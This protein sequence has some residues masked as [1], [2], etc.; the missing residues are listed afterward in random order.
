[1]WGSVSVSQEA[2]PDLLRECKDSPPKFF[3]RGSWDKNLFQKAVTVAGARRM[4]GYGQE[5]TREIVSKLALNGITIIS[6]LTYGIEAYAQKTA[7]DFR[8]RAI[9]VM[10][11]GIECVWPQYHRSLYQKILDNKGL[12]ISEFAG[13]FSPKPWMFSRRKL[14]LSLISPALL[15]IE[16][17]AKSN[18]LDIARTALK[19]KRKVFSVPGAVTN[20]LY[21]GSLDL[22]KQG[23]EM[24]VCAE[25]ILKFFGVDSNSNKDIFREDLQFSGLEKG[26]FLELKRQGMSLDELSKTLEVNISECAGAVSMMQLAGVISEKQ[27]RYFIVKSNVN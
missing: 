22:I 9:A 27:G 24:A 17:S 15:V 8:G 20:S 12:I 19:Y 26:I 6:G 21:Q 4:S 18:T 3:Y 16:A 7:L 10:P 13:G 5:V 2:Y 25:D 23:A 14:S 11:C 1:M